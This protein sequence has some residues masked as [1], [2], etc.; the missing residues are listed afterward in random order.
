MNDTTK[1]LF[2]ALGVVIVGL[3]AFMLMFVI[4]GLISILDIDTLTLCFEYALPIAGV[5]YIVWIYRETIN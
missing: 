4:I 1:E 3:L 5:T 2:K